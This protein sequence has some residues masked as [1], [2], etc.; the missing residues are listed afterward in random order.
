MNLTIYIL[1]NNTKLKPPVLVCRGCYFFNKG[2][3]PLDTINIVTIP[4]M[5][6]MHT[7]RPF[8]S[9]PIFLFFSDIFLSEGQ[10]S[11]E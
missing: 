2:N 5:L 1:S 7:R 4:C 3:L 9:V 8:L 10:L 6:E 11:L